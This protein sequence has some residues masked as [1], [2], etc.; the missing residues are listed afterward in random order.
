[1]RKK[2]KF[3]VVWEGREKGIFDSWE[4]T[5]VQIDH[6]PGAKYK[7]F[8]QLEEAEKAFKSNYWKVIEQNKPTKTSSKITGTK[9]ILPSLSVDAACS[10]NPGVLEY[11]G[12]DTESK[13][14]VFKRGPFPIGTINIGEFLAIVHGL[15][16]L[17]KEKID[18]PLYSDSKTAIS[19][20]KNK[21][22]KTNL[23]R[24][25][26]T[27]ELFSLVDKAL[28]W[29]KNNPDHNKVFKWETEIWGENPAD[30]GRK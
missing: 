28:I 16:L 2:Q 10:G 4:K 6:F 5:F 13:N 15:A 14:R 21:A 20:V 3:Y 19:W 27:E 29:L 8:D 22:I 12:V 26:A 1:M 17:K 23:P 18:Y 24:N 9:P 30:Y 25:K 7:S 11:Q